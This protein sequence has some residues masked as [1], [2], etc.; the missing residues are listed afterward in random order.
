MTTQLSVP[1]PPR[2]PEDQA[3][4]NSATQSVGDELLKL[5]ERGVIS[6]RAANALYQSISTRF[7]RDRNADIAVAEKIVGS[8]AK[9]NQA[10]DSGRI[11][12]EQLSNALPGEYFSDPSQRSGGIGHSVALRNA[13][14][15]RSNVEDLSKK[16]DALVQKLV[17]AETAA[18]TLGS[19]S[20][21]SMP[22]R[23]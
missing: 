13:K 16:L 19:L 5:A 6:D 22:Q 1:Q 23:A 12:D 20:M 10:L 14:V 3:R 2:T 7:D 21:P 17:P 11:K 9:L 4:L 15:Y 18:M 8:L